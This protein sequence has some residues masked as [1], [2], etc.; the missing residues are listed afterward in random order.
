MV[1]SFFATIDVIKV[2]ERRHKNNSHNFGSCVISFGVS[3]PLEE[4]AGHSGS[5]LLLQSN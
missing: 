3:G 4:A 5:C 1:A 2:H